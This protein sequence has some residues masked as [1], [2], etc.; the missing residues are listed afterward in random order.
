MKKYLGK[1]QRIYYP[2]D[3]IKIIKKEI[4][5]AEKVT[6][7]KEEPKSKRKRQLGFLLEFALATLTIFFLFSAPAYFA[8]IKNL[9]F[10]NSGSYYYLYAQDD[11]FSEGNGNLE[12]LSSFFSETE[13]ELRLKIPDLN[14]EI[15]VQE[16]KDLE[17]AKRLLNEGA[18]L[19]V[20]EDK[21]QNFKNL[22]I[23]GHSSVYPWQ[24]SQPVFATLE[25]IKEG[26]L[27][28]LTIGGQ[29]SD[30]RVVTKRVVPKEEL[31]FLAKPNTTLLT[32]MTC[33]PVGT[34]KNRLLVIA[35]KI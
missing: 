10:K 9:L 29:S 24:K 18:V 17:T 35:E 1:I 5:V 14:L 32:L 20:E 22:L 6:G 16:A 15:A 28:T 30:F 19:L 25:E 3:G 11:P 13:K 23:A 2:N 4:L 27:I 8:K 12:T 31:S 21:N 34:T 33:V 26:A 7:S